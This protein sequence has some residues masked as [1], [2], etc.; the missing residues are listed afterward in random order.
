[1]PTPP[2]APTS[3]AG[4]K[5]REMLRRREREL[6]AEVA[7]GTERLRAI[8]ARSLREPGDLEDTAAEKIAT[9][10]GDAE[11]ERDLAELHQVEEA[12]QRLEAGQYGLC[13]DC[14]DAIDPR[15][16]KAEPFALR[17]VPCQGRAEQLAAQ[18]RR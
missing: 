13:K 11:V 8:D 15:R 9:G 17:C 12:L 10:V 18:M 4:A 2:I 5:L 6:R 7:A 14:G 3:P 1:M 16:L